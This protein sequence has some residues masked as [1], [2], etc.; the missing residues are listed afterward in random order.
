MC[1]ACDDEGACVHCGVP[2]EQA[3]ADADSAAV[4]LLRELEWR[5]DHAHCP[6]CYGANPKVVEGP[7][8]Q[9]VTGGLG[10]ASDCRL[11]KLLGAPTRA[12]D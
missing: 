8:A 6:D 9:Y 3:E 10:H 4:A 2:T 12:A 1:T 7:G 11:A 5:I